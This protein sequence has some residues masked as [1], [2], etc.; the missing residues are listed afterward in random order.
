MK[1]QKKLSREE[2]K[3]I[4]G[5]IPKGWVEI[6]CDVNGQNEIEVSPCSPGPQCSSGIFVAYHLGTCSPY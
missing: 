5:G 6:I 4:K 3:S 1:N 2:L